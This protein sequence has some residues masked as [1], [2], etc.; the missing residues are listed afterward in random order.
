[1]KLEH[2]L[3]KARLRAPVVS[4]RGSLDVRELLLVRLEGD[5]GFVG[6]GEAAPLVS[7]D[8]VSIE[9]VRAALEDCREVLAASDGSDPERV[10]ADCVQAAVLP[11]A[12]A[13]V[14]LALW[15][16][17]GRR[18]GEP[19]WR[20]LGARS[21]E[22]VSVNATITAPDRAGAARQAGEFVKRGF[23]CLKLKV[24]VGDDAA[25]VA[26]VRAAAGQDAQI[27][28]DANGA[29][30]VDQ[31]VPMLRA[32]E[33]AGIELCEEPVSGLQANAEVAEA[34]EVPIAIDESSALPGALDARWCD[35]VCLKIT[36]C[37][38]ISGVLDAARRARGAG[39]SVYLAS[40]FDG[41]I[42]IAGALHVASALAPDRPC[43]LATL[44]I[45]EGREDPLGPS[46]GRLAMPAGAGLGEGLTAWYLR[47]ER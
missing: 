44:D 40:T 16:L 30:S 24:G 6:V 23:S 17:A 7:Y 5:D 25:R 45:F 4:A 10:L 39:Y 37:G 41:P 11:Q 43:G 22:P 8:G 29:W 32:L 27:R 15:D 12:S 26:A 46:E 18:A 21:P 2:E 13:A 31:A 42:G 34:C 14:D 9:D 35:S 33:P 3:I 20:M 36:R 47:P 28:L 38:G 1:M 19:V